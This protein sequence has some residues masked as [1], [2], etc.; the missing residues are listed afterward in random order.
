MPY[1]QRGRFVS[2][3]RTKSNPWFQIFRSYWHTTPRVG[4]GSGLRL[5]T[6]RPNFLVRT[7]D[8]AYRCLAEDCGKRCSG[9][10]SGRSSPMLDALSITTAPIEL[11]RW[12][13]EFDFDHH[14][15]MYLLLEFRVQDKANE[16]TR[17]SH[18]EWLK[19]RHATYRYR[20]RKTD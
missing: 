20:L 17:R 15:P 12:P 7:T 1:E 10:G 11:G 3:L 13:C 9:Q 19:Y 4:H 2:R 6:F 16:S 14:P 8:R 5:E 18:H